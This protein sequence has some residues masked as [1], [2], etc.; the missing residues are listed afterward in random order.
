ML[1]VLYA[2]SKANRLNFA[3]NQVFFHKMTQFVATNRQTNYSLK[4]IN[5]N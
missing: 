4:P 3:F 5:F 2:L 1:L